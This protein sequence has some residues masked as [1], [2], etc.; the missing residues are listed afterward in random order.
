MQAMKRN[1]TVWSASM[2]VQ[3]T[4]VELII[5]LKTARHNVR[6][7]YRWAE[8][9]Y[10]R[11]PGMADELVS[12]RA[13]VLATLGGAAAHAAKSASVKVSPAVP[14]V[15][16]LGGDPVAEGL[17]ASLNRPGGN[18]TGSISIGGSLAPSRFR[19]GFCTQLQAVAPPAFFTRAAQCCVGHAAAVLTLANLYGIAE[20]WKMLPGAM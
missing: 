10:D 19:G 7:E 14:V 11:L 3:S 15:F 9:A 1:T 5:N 12:L 17:V 18:M 20:F 16:A 8:G 4:K 2:P 13:N 6:I